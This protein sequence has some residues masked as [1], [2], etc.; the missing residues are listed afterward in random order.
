MTTYIQKPAGR[1][2]PEDEFHWTLDGAPVIAVVVSVWVTDPYESHRRVTIEFRVKD[3]GLDYRR[4]AIFEGA[5]VFVHYQLLMTKD[6]DIVYEEL[7]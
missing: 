3:A 1:L 7:V 5:P 2:E 6:M 4:I